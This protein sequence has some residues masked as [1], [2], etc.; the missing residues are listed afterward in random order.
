MKKHNL[1]DG[2]IFITTPNDKD[3]FNRYIA[4]IS[5]NKPLKREEEVDLFK[6]IE[7][8]GDKEAILK[9]YEHNLLF[10]IS[11]A[12]RY[13]PVIHN[14][15]IT[16]ED[17]INE[18]N[19]GLFLAIPRFDYKKGNKF[20][21]YA[22][23]W[24]RQSILACIQK[25]IKS[26]TIP[27]KC[28]TKLNKITKKE[29]FLQQKLGREVSNIEIFEA[30][31]EDGDMDINDSEEKIDEIKSMSLFDTSLNLYITESETTEII[32]TIKSDDNEPYDKLEL[33]ERLE[34]VRN[35]LDN[36]PINVKEYFSH[37]FGLN[38]FDVLKTKEIAEKYGVSESS[39]RSEINIYLKRLKYRYKLSRKFF[40]P[41]PDY[42]FHKTW[43]QPCN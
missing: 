20:I 22:V 13:Y 23:W 32:D 2:T 43:K 34:L 11:V 3:T 1:K 4:E 41:T 18:G 10:V 30:M 15:V 6:K 36:L 16:L 8:N 40:F 28:A 27:S 24:I 38:G 25:N 19:I 33:K 17:L 39:I 35:M 21:S 26:V 37:Y 5:K 7:L 12:K 14:T 9:I 31:L 29:S 42:T